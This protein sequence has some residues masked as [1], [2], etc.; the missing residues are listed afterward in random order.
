MTIDLECLLISPEVTIREAMAVIESAPHRVGLSGIAVVVDENRH[1]LGVVTD[2]DIRSAILHGTGL[3]SPVTTIMTTDPI[4]VTNHGAPKQM[5]DT[6]MELLKGSTRM[7]DRGAGKV[8]VVDN[9]KRVVDVVSFFNLWQQADIRSKKVAVLGLGFVGLTLAVVLADAG[10]Q[11]TG[12]ENRGEVVESLRQG[13]PHFYEAGLANQLRTHLDRQLKIESSLANNECDIYIISVGT[14][15][16]EDHHPVL[17]HVETACRAI[18]RVLKP[19][20]TIMLRSTVSVGTTRTYCL[21][22]LQEESGLRGGKDFSLVFAPERTIAGKALKELRTLPQ[23]IGSMDPQG[24]EI[25]ASF[26]RE[27]TPIIVMLDSLEAAEMVKLVNNAFRDTVFSFSNEIALVCERYGLDVF[28]IIDAANEGY[29]RDPVPMP[30]PGVGGVCLKKDPYLLKSTA[31]AGGIEPSIIGRS[32]VVNEYMPY[33]VF[34]KFLR[35]LETKGREP[36]GSKVFVVG[37]AFKGWPETS[38]MRDSSTLELVR[39]LRQAAVRIFGYDPVIT[40]QALSG[41]PGVEPCSLVDGFKDAECVFV[42]NNHPSYED[43]NLHAYL[44][45]MNMPGLFVDGWSIFRSDDIAR[46]AGISYSSLSQNSG[47]PESAEAER[48]EPKSVPGI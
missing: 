2:G 30:S 19:G 16:G 39:Y 29:P 3:D 20:D 23:I 6:V 4:A 46:V 31:L 14:P 26:Y 12:I 1:L 15:I 9:E 24:A 8:V 22:W 11:V 28:K 42:M 47:W 48:I 7:L 38:D 44:A 33:H 41:I 21:P 43:W 32:R 25:A 10:F 13:V 45:S 18:G 37:F 5:Y 40:S 35:F 27:I 36:A 17:N 34:Q